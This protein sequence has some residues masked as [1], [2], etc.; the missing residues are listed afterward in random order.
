M[1][2]HKPVEEEVMPWDCYYGECDHDDGDD[3]TVTM[4]VCDTCRDVIEFEELESFVKWPCEHVEAA[5]APSYPK[6]EL[7][8]ATPAEQE[9]KG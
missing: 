4:T 2:E 3:H 9:G 6:L 1:S 8:V 7:R 5:A